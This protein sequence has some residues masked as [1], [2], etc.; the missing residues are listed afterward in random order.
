MRPL[1]LDDLPTHSVWA[2]YLL[3]PTGDPPDT[4]EAYT[5]VELYEEMYAELLAKYRDEPVSSGEFTET[6]YA[7][8]R[9]DP[10]P[11]S[12]REEL[13]LANPEEVSDRDRDVVQDAVARVDIDPATVL[14]LGCGYGAALEPLAESFPDA[15]VIGGE[16][17]EAGVDL[18]QE[19]HNE[20][21]RISVEWFDVRDSWAL[22]D[23]AAQPLVFT[24][25]IVTALPSAERIVDRLA[26]RAQS[27]AV[28]GGVHLEQVDEHPETTLGLLRRHHSRVRG[29]DGE[30]LAMLE[31]HD[32]IDIVETEYDI[33]GANPLHPMTLI[34]WRPA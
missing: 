33:L 5:G 28:L 31:E 17:S 14:D 8:G 30:L 13:F 15:E 29:Y 3:D 24:R 21:D 10:G 16:Y 2:R 12:V 27:G 32:A 23:H 20:R 22:F 6:V 7:A 25:G 34:C 18:A 9:D 26:E 11:V 4:P 19:L 1:A